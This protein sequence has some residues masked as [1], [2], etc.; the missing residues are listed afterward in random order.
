M[1]EKYLKKIRDILASRTEPKSRFAFLKSCKNVMVYGAGNCGKDVLSILVRHGVP[2]L[3]FLDWKVPSGTIVNGYMVLPPDDNSIS[4]D[5]R[6]T[7]CVV[8]GIF[9]R[10]ADVPSITKALRKNGFSNVVNFP[11]FHSHFPDETGDRYW[12]TSTKF[13]DA[14]VHILAEGLAVWNDQK[15]RQLYESI[16]KFRFTGDYKFLPEPEGGTQYFDP[17]M[18]RWKTPINFVDCGSYTGDTLIELSGKYG[19]V[20]HISAFEP[21]P[22]NFANLNR[23]VRSRKIPFGKTI[24]LFPCAVWSHTTQM[25]F[26]TAPQGGAGNLSSRGD[27]TVQCVA[28][29]ECL[30]HFHPTLIKMDVEGAELSALLGAKETIRDSRPGLAICLYHR[31]EHLWQIPLLLKQ[32]DPRYEFALRL[33][34][35]AGFDLVMYAR[36]S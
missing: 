4:T 15:S 3:C 36:P 16:L 31:P 12:L 29:D 18:P 17:K 22:E 24:V 20:N 34:R 35:H 26:S 27:I 25:N 13:Y 30:H 9:N 32:W 11:E 14:L 19:R 10:D 23:L 7:T 21:D 6:K 1:N 28:I 33:Y 2:V 5:Q 8:I